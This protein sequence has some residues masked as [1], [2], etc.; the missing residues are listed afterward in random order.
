MAV[1]PRWWFRLAGERRVSARRPVV[2][3]D[4]VL[5][6]FSFDKAAFTQSRLISFHL[7]SGV[8]NWSY[9]V[10]HVANEPVATGDG[11]YW[12]SFEGSIH[13]LGRDGKLLWRAPGGASNLGAPVVADGRVVVAEIGGGAGSTWCLDAESGARLWQFEHGGHAYAPAAG[14]GRVFHSSAAHTRIGER[15]RCTLHAIA[16]D[17]GRPEWSVADPRYFFN[18]IVNQDHLYVC[19]SRSFQVRRADTG[20]LLCE[21]PLEREDRTLV[22]SGGG[23]ASRFYV[24]R[25]SH[26]QGADSLTAIDVGTSRGLLGRKISATVAWR[27]EE[28]RGLCGSPQV[29][30]DDLAV[31]LTHP[32]VLCWIDTRTGSVVRETA[33]RT[34]A[35]AAGGVV[36][37]PDSL[38]VSHGAQVLAFGLGDDTGFVRGDGP[39]HG[40]AAA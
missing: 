22:L 38:I 30:G 21:L 17:S 20:R 37:T 25:D 11:T 14:E 5:V 27:R 28:P 9:V 3:G 24:W 40:A 39:G 1:K 12:S 16:V 33:L 2:S 6:S 26:G 35:S 13:A 19:S 29:L 7:S 10:D 15:T 18:P 36:L 4:D 32:G 23:G 34:P 31:C 8:E